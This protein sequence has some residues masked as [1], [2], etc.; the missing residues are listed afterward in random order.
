MLLKRLSTRISSIHA[1]P[2]TPV[3]SHWTQCTAYNRH[4]LTTTS[5]YTHTQLTIHRYFSSH[6]S[7]SHDSTHKSWSNP[8]LQSEPK[9]D[10]EQTININIITM[11]G[12]RTNV[13]GKTGESLL[14][15]IKRS[16]V[17]G[18]VP[19]ACDAGGM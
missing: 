9:P 1:F 12:K 11:E 4:T 17:G 15:A 16:D 6:D 7:H 14:D 10:N 8:A 18:M 5:N 19:A 3:Q 13:K 2:C